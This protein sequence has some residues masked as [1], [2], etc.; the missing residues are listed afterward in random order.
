SDATGLF[1]LIMTGTEIGPTKLDFPFKLDGIDDYGYL[2]IEAEICVRINLLFKIGPDVEI[3]PTTI[4]FGLVEY[5][6]NVE[7]FVSVKNMSP[8]LAK[9]KIREVNP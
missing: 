7:K 4:D 9:C 5:G 6:R 8:I 2:H 1:T 3:E